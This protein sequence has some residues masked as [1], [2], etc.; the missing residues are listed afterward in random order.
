MKAVRFHEF[1]RSGRACARGR[2]GSPSPRPGQVLIEIGACAL[3]HLD[4]DIREGVSRFPVEPPYIP[5][6][7]IVGRIAAVGEGVDR[8]AGRATA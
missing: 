5:G 2:R 8:L 4:V 6:L 7:E 1:G 3:N